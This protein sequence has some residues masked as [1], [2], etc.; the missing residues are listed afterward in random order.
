[1]TFKVASYTEFLSY[2]SPTFQIYRL[3]WRKDMGKTKQ[4]VTLP[5]KY[6]TIT[7]LTLVCGWMRKSTYSNFSALLDG[8]VVWFVRIFIHNSQWKGNMY[9]K[10]HV[11]RLNLALLPR[12]HPYSIQYGEKRKE[13]ST[14]HGKALKGYTVSQPSYSHFWLVRNFA[15]K[16]IMY[17][18]TEIIY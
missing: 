3:D 7:M 18:L 6:S 17:L 4:K 13:K 2:N 14:M 15:D 16:W 5:W 10:C 12:G 1:M 8:K 11:L 9:I